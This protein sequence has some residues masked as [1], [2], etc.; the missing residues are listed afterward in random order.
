MQEFGYFNRPS[1]PIRRL[2]QPI[3]FNRLLGQV[4]YRLELDRAYKQLQ[5]RLLNEG[6]A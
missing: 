2:P 3:N 1:P 5:V 6:R 4:E